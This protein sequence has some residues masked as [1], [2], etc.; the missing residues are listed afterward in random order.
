[1]G[2]RCRQSIHA[3]YNMQ[4]AALQP[5]GTVTVTNGSTASIV[6]QIPANTQYEWYAV[7]NNGNSNTTGPFWG[8]TTPI[9]YTLTVN[10]VGSGSIGKV[11]DQ[12]TYLYGDVVTLTATPAAGWTFNNWSGD[13]SGS[14]SPAAITINANKTVTATFTPLDIP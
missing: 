4:G 12:A 11:P 2:N 9:A 7:V 8:F 3:E 6:L 5:I 14:T 10:T 13:L 1:M